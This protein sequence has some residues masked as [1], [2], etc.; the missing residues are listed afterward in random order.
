MAG[1]VLYI[2]AVIAKDVSHVLDRFTSGKARVFK[3]TDASSFKVN[4]VNAVRIRGV[5]VVCK[6]K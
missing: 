6:W 3:R 5:D 2:D 4:Q 1:A